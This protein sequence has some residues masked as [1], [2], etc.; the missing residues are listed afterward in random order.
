[1]SRPE[2]MTAANAA[3]IL[4]A[5]ATSASG[6]VVLQQVH[7]DSGNDL[8]GYSVGAA[9]DVDHDGRRD[10]MV[11]APWDGVAKTG[12]ARLISGRTG[13]VLAT[14]TGDSAG[15]EFGTSVAGLGD[16]DQDGTADVVVGSHL[17]DVGA[18]DTGSAYVYSGAS[19]APL[20]AFHGAHP[21]DNLGACVADAGDFDS[22]GAA[23]FIVASHHYSQTFHHAGAVFV[24][25]G[26]TG[27]LLLAVFGAA[28]DQDVGH[29]V[30]V[31]G[32]V[33][34]DGHVDLLIGAHGFAA[35]AGAAFVV[36][37]ATA[38]VIHTFQGD[39]AGDDMG[40]A[41][42]AAGD[43]NQDGFDDFLVGMTGDDN[44]GPES[45]AARV[46]SGANGAVLFHF[47]GDA[48]GDGFGQAVLGGFDFSGDGVPDFAV[49]APGDDGAGMNTGSVRIRSGATCAELHEIDGASPGLRFWRAF[50]AGDFDADGA[51]DLVVGIPYDDAA[52]ADSGA[53]IVYSGDQLGWSDA[54]FALAGS[55]GPPQ[56]SGD[57]WLAAGT[58]TT[59]AL[60]NAK[61]AAMAVLFIGFAKIQAPLLGGIVVPA[62]DVVVAGLPTGTGSLALGAA[63]PAGVPSRTAIWFQAWIADPS[64]PH[65]ATASNAVKA[66]V[67]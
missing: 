51:D 17:N 2:P 67:P 14:W 21:D 19:G 27:G 57:G 64:G 4:L 58:T 12:S 61:P 3:L 36:S 34:L 42:S 35:G 63:W 15:D 7:G 1:M 59:L 32:D 28:V 39:N 45:G 54:G 25:S 33:D 41:V 62:P 24:R 26:A 11:G 10:F 20:Y 13:A 8:C 47:D 16:V 49:G 18:A 9:G 66:L 40:R 5:L 43:V 55:L 46:F 53:T 65:G 48:P 6:Q 52:G 44:H 31:T 29:S 23:D 56:L 30:A 22:D 60:A 38:A 37:G 50:A